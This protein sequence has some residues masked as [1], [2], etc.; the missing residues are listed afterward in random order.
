MPCKCILKYFKAALYL[1]NVWLKATSLSCT[2]TCTYGVYV[3]KSHRH[4]AAHFLCITCFYNQRQQTFNDKITKLWLFI[5]TYVV[6]VWQRQRRRRRL[7][8]VSSR[9]VL[10]GLRLLLLIE[11][12][13]EPWPILASARASVV[14]WAKKTQFYSFLSFHTTGCVYSLI[15][16]F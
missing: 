5:I 15:K 8:G 6:A 2:S 3:R 4:F 10:G 11:I 9:G 13:E 12:V 1:I 14:L 16:F 7:N